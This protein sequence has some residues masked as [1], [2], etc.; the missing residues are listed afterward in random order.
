MSQTFEEFIHSKLL[1]ALAF[2]HGVCVK[3]KINYSLY[4]GSLIGAIRHKG[5]IPWDDDVDVAMTREEYKKFRKIINNYCG[6]EFYFNDKGDRVPEVNY[7]QDIFYDTHKLG[8]LG[9]DIYIID[10]LPDDIKKRRAL[11]LKLKILQGMMKKGK[12]KYWH[13]YDLKGKILVLSTKF[14]G[15]FFSLNKLARMYEKATQRYN[16][17][18]S[19]DRYVSND[20]YAVFDRPFESTLFEGYMTVPF[21]DKE[22]IIFANADPILRV[23]YGDYMILPPESERHFYHTAPPQEN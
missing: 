11:I 1:Y 10:N 6:E 8:D 17:Q 13:K 12:L 18:Q 19:K 15:A 5:F 20:L 4:G 9:I 2:F 16:D 7:K 3:E 21:E 22:F 14:L 23:Q